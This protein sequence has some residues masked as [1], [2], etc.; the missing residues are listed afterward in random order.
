MVSLLPKTDGPDWASL[1]I[2]TTIKSSN[3]AFYGKYLYSVTWRFPFAFLLREW[4]QP[5]FN[6]D[7]RLSTYIESAGRH[8]WKSPI[9]DEHAVAVREIYDAIYARK[10][11]DFRFRIEGS[12]ITFFSND[13][14]M[15]FELTRTV[16]G[17][18]TVHTAEV[19]RPKSEEHA[20]QLLDGKVKS[21]IPFK[22]K[23]ITRCAEMSRDEK[24]A[25]LNILNQEGHKVNDRL[26]RTLSEPYLR[27]VQSYF[28]T[29]DMQVMTLISLIHPTFIKKIH[30][31]ISE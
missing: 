30:T 25:I 23:A 8:R 13:E 22:Y 31:I 24:D 14:Q 27:V 7:T 3:R 5:S 21:T 12:Y 1:P 26:K 29:N 16:A 18:T 20:K 15:L 6:I 19:C 28:Y 9:S 4:K 17:T 11:E 10:D 2:R